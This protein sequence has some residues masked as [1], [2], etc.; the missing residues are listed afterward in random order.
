LIDFLKGISPSWVIFI[1]KRVRGLLKRKWPLS[2]ANKELKN[3]SNEKTLTGKILLKMAYDRNPR[4]TMFADKVAVRDYVKSKVGEKYLSLEIARLENPEELR[5]LELPKNFALKSNHGS[6][7]MIL[8]WEGASLDQGLP[9]RPRKPNWNQYLIHPNSWNQDLAIKLCK[10][11]LYQNY[12]YRVG[13]YPEWGYKDIKPMLLV[14]ELL[15]NSKNELPEDYK[16]F[17]ANGRCQFI[18]VDTSRFNGHCRDL[19]TTDWTHIPVENIYPNS[20]QNL[21]KPSSLEEMVQVAEKLGE[22]TDFIRVD[23]YV[24]SKGIKFGELTNYPGGGVEPYS[25]NEFDFLLCQSWKP[26]YQK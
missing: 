2:L 7:A 3:A 12:F 17:V 9:N 18:Q 21:E 22:D 16:F 24:T 13:Q 19:Y 4:L 14:E 23:L 5:G 10:Q 6:G 25:P 20:G 15:T 26:N 11:W 8:V 1:L